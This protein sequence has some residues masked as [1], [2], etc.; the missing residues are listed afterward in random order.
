T[1]VRR[2]KWGG[3]RE[4]EEGGPDEA[5]ERGAP[6]AAGGAGTTARTF[7]LTNALTIDGWYGDAY[8]DLI[9]DRTDTAIVLGAAADSFGA[10]QIAARLGLETTGI[11]LPLT[12]VADNVRTPERAQHPMLV[13]G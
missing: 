11:T 5:G 12:R 10:T 3:V 8:A 6:A 9:P 2:V 1:E 4:H 13:G 7:D